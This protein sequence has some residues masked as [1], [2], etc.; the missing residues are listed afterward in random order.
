MELHSLV[1]RERSGV[2]SGPLWTGRD[3]VIGPH[4]RWLR[5]MSPTGRLHSPFLYGISAILKCWLCG[6]N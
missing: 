1:I 5:S 2:V 4:R 3:R 6:G